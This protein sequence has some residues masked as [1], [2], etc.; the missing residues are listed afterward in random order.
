MLLTDGFEVLQTLPPKKN[1]VLEIRE[2]L[3]IAEGIPF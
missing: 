3:R 1:L 2:L